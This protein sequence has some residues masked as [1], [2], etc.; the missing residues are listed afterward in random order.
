MSLRLYTL[1]E[2]SLVLWVGQHHIKQQRNNR[3]VSRC[4]R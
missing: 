4:D 3:I 2:H 1:Y